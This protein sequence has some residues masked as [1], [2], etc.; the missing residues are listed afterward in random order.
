MNMLESFRS[1][2]LSNYDWISTPLFNIATPDSSLVL[3]LNH[4]LQNKSDRFFF[5][6]TQLQK[7]KK[8]NPC[9]FNFIDFDILLENFNGD[10]VLSNLTTFDPSVIL[11]Y[12]FTML[13]TE[14]EKE[15]ETLDLSGTVMRSINT[16]LSFVPKKYYK[17]VYACSYYSCNSTIIQYV[18]KTLGTRNTSNTICNILNYT[19]ALAYKNNFTNIVLG[20]ISKRY[21]LFFEN[22][23]IKYPYSFCQFNSIVHAISNLLNTTSTPYKMLF[24]TKLFDSANTILKQMNPKHININPPEILYPHIFSVPNNLQHTFYYKCLSDLSRTDFIKFLENQVICNSAEIIH[25]IRQTPHA[26]DIEFWE[27]LYK[28]I[29]DDYIITWDDHVFFDKL[30]WTLFIQ[31]N[32][33]NDL[34]FR[35]VKDNK[36][37]LLSYV[38]KY[39][40]T[41]VI[42]NLTQYPEIDVYINNQFTKRTKA[43]MYLACL[44]NTNN[45]DKWFITETMN[46]VIEAYGVELFLSEFEEMMMQHTK[47]NPNILNFILERYPTQNRQTQERCIVS[48]EIPETYRLCKS[49]VPH[50]ISVDVYTKLERKV[51]PYCRAGFQHTIYHNKTLEH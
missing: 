11:C 43:F 22:L 34:F 4:V 12:I 24:T 35:I 40:R 36:K 41:I 14:Y 17:E 2:H 50:V 33:M 49:N 19:T 51:C 23:P 47:F 28:S 31:K 7:N 46:I 30:P 29:G 9:L 25:F 42:N 15:K 5:V 44:Q 8:I 13:N 20:Y 21:H 18:K 1:V 48:Y 39:Y 26:K 37:N 38:L 27:E 32:Y 45:T 16:L 3:H 6:M 10:L